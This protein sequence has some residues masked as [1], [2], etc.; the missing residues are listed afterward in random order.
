MENLKVTRP[1]RRLNGAQ[2]KYLTFV[3]MFIDHMSNSTIT[4]CLKGEGFLLYLS[5]FFSILDRIVFP[6]FFSFLME[7]LFQTH[8]CKGY[9]KD[10]LFSGLISEV[11]FDPLASKAFSD[12]YW[13]DIFSSL[14]MVLTTIWVIDWLRGRLTGRVKLLWYLISLPTLLGIGALSM[15]L[16]LNHDYHAILVTYF[17]YFLRG[18]SRRGPTLGYLPTLKEFWFFLGFSLILT[19][20]G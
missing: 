18:R 11:P 5:N 16:S 10:L 6:I 4:P 17:L 1:W 8:S 9:L 19:Y 12:P 7:G 2:L 14:A 3:F 13:D 20:S 15:Y